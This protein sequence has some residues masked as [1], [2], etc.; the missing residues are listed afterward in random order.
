MC[1]LARTCRPLRSLGSR[2]RAKGDKAASGLRGWRTRDG[3]CA[4]IPCRY[5]RSIIG[6]E[7][8]T[9]AEEISQGRL[10]FKVYPMNEPRLHGARRDA[11][12]DGVT[13]HSPT[14]AHYGMIDILKSS[15]RPFS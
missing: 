14:G 6:A 1:P 11:G 13:H 3:Y 4:G 2:A 9:A 7:A 10:H 12:V 8:E 5:G 15:A